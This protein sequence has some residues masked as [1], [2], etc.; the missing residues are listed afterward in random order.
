[1]LPIKVSSLA[2]NTRKGPAGQRCHS[3]S[4]N[5][6]NARVSSIER[7]RSQARKRQTSGSLA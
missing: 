5:A 4:L 3:A 2:E 7:C 1:V 6:M